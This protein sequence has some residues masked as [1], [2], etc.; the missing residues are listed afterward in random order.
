M[1]QV[2]QFAAKGENPDRETLGRFQVAAAAAPLRPE[3][4]QVQAAIA[5]ESGDLPRAEGLLVAAR[6]RD[7]R[8]AAT[9]YL[10]ADV[11][12]RQGKVV[13]GLSELAILSRL[14][15]AAT[16]QLV[17]AL[18]QFARTAGARDKLYAILQSNPQLRRPLLESLAADPANADLVVS[19]AGPDSRSSEPRA[20]HWKARLLGGFIQ[21]GDYTGAYRLWRSFA[22]LP[23]TASPL[24]FNG[25]FRTTPAPPP[26]NWT[27][28]S[29]S[30]G[31]AEPSDG[32]LRVL[33]Y[34]RENA[35][36]ASQLLLLTPGA[37]R[38]EAPVSGSVA[39]GALEWTLSCARSGKQVMT[40]PLA[41][42][43]PEIRFEIPEGCSAQELVLRGSA[44][45]MPENSDIRIGPVAIERTRP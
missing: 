24:L 15:P 7:P 39:D 36:L 5:E 8:A 9:R 32:K 25:G 22:G 18:S 10:L 17:P 12:L 16:V 43:N 2:G 13:E 23:G 45:E 30:A 1:K 14:F 33:F 38:F 37:Y 41:G 42:A 4:F 3:P 31:V 44:Q 35:E 40:L 27:Y 21:K 11:E 34:G 6:W 26:F 29:G 28:S 19:L 20:Q